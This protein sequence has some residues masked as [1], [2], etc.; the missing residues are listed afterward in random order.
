MSKKV[1]RLQPGWT[2]GRRGGRRRSDRIL[3][4]AERSLRS[5]TILLTCATLVCYLLLRG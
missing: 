3:R 5:I 1:A 2:E 4:E